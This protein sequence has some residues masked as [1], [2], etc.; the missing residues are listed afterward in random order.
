MTKKAIDEAKVGKIYC[1]GFYH[2][3]VGDMIGYLQY[4]AGLTPV[5]CLNEREFYSA[6]FEQGDCVS[7]RSPLVDPCLLY[8]SY[9]FS[10]YI[11]CFEC[12]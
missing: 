1:S 5:G 11:F 10:Y 3:G 7:F 8:T 12:S 2:T 9:N 6:N 4:A